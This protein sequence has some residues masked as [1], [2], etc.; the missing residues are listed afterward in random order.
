LLDAGER[1]RYEPSAVV[2]HE[3]PERRLQQKYFLDWWFDKARADIRA[4]GVPAVTTWRLGRIALVLF[5]RLAVW[6][7]RWMVAVEPS[8]R[9]SCKLK[10]WSVAG[11]I[12][13]CHRHP[14]THR[15]YSHV[16]E[17]G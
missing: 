5:R 1:L 13:E 6:T 8:R 9:F 7:L 11:Q 4:S 14:A 15:N 2:F 12:V 17:R 10:V 3:I 16:P